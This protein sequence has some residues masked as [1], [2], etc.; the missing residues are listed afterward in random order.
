M[1][2]GSYDIE[3]MNSILNKTVAAIE[4]SKEAIFDIAENA[5]KACNSI[6]KQ[7]EETKQ[8]MKTLLQEVELVE[9]LEKN[10]RKRLLQVSKDFSKYSE[11]DIKKAYQQANE[12]QIKL[13]LKRQEENDLFRYRTEL[14]MRFKQSEDT[15][16][17]AEELVSKIGVAMEYLTGNLQDLT[18]TLE[19]I[20]VKQNIGRRII[21]A[22]E[23]ERQRV[24]R[25]IHDG[26]AQ[27]FANVIIKAEICEK[28]MDIDKEKS[29]IE[30]Q[31]LRN[32]LR[33][34][35]KDI[36]KIIYNLRPMAIDDLGFIPMVQRYIE[37]F[38][39]DTGIAVDFIILSQSQMED[40]VKNLSIFRVIQESLNNIKKHS[41]AK[42][43]K[44]KLEMNKKGISLYII[45]DGIGFELNENEMEIRDD[46]G[47]GITNMKERVE[48]L[49]G[50][51]QIRSEVNKGTKINV[52]I[53]YE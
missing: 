8:K 13:I 9:A 5:R 30:L 23:E 4:E 11:E 22:Q 49:N 32:I 25:D 45:D 38:Q 42:N 31:V 1:V 51:L 21:R 40:Q 12:L 47:F 2:N 44:I 3:E 15:L 36:R 24:A 14:E 33:E 35:V 53:P 10:G 50:S 28:L 37:V 26:P 29:K 27:T 39:K 7:L 34:G 6:K 48:L 20:Q 46:G 18:T 17:K 43:V 52:N 19:D 16:K 41:G